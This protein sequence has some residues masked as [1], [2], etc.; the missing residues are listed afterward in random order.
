MPAHWALISVLLQVL[1]D[2]HALSLRT[3][4]PAAVKHVLGS[5]A[6]KLSDLVPQS[7]IF[8]AYS[9]ARIVLRL[10]QPWLIHNDT[11]KSF[12]CRRLR[13]GLP[14]LLHERELHNSL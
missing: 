12:Y 11:R 10:I 7:H 3:F 14:I 4:E 6:W 8:L 9:T 5:R 13:D 1:H 2:A